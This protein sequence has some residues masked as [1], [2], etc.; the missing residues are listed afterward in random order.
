MNVFIYIEIL[1][2]STILLIGVNYAV[3]HD[4][5][6]GYKIIVLVCLV[7]LFKYLDLRKY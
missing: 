3:N 2:L 4:Y 7:F 5:I 6:F 1:L